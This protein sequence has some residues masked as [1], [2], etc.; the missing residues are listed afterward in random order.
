MAKAKNINCPKCNKRVAKWD[1]KSTIN[2]KT[3]CSN[4]K[5]QV[6]FLIEEQKTLL[7]PIPPRSSS[8][9]ITF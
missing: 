7:K 2:I 9:G 6:V 5:K 8:S 1:G 4:C 3:T